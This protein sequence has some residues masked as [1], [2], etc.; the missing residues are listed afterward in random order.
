MF[1]LNKSVLLFGYIN[2]NIYGFTFFFLLG[3]NTYSLSV[4]FI[5]Q[6]IFR[7]HESK[8]TWIWIFIQSLFMMFAHNC[9]LG[10]RHFFKAGDC[11]ALNL[12]I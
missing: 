9:Q 5:Q 1:D 7:S 6:N 8:Y 3:I 4:E 12:V 11:S 10:I 2:P